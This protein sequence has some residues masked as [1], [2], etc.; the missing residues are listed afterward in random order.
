MCS[1]CGLLRVRACGAGE[2]WHG[3]CAAATWVVTAERAIAVASVKADVP[4]PSP[5]QHAH[6]S[7]CMM[8]GDC[9]TM[10]LRRPA[11]NRPASHDKVQAK[12]LHLSNDA[13]INR[14]QVTGQAT[15]AAY[16]PARAEP[17]PAALRSTQR[18]DRLP[19]RVC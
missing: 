8:V 2:A 1:G 17:F 9:C 16:G 13:F 15:A 18:A 5:L 6:S 11:C 14:P 7:N 10:G 12:T 4:L 3:A 19:P